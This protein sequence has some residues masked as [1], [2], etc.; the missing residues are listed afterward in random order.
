MWAQEWVSGGCSMCGSVGCTNWL[1]ESL[2]RLLWQLF[3][4]KVSDRKMCGKCCGPENIQ[5]M[6]GGAPV[7]FTVAPLQFWVN[8]G[9]R[10]AQ[11]FGRDQMFVKVWQVVL[12]CGKFFTT[13]FGDPPWPCT[14]GGKSHH[15]T[16]PANR[17]TAVAWSNH[18]QSCC[19]RGWG[20]GGAPGELQ[21]N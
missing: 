9:A 5:N 18:R 12:G 13:K 21:R 16:V 15:P 7:S 11:F 4:V 6:G 10:N 1:V 19:C 3:L 2:G 20:P 17:V 14:S 8:P